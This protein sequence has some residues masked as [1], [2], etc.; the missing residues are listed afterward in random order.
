MTRPAPARA[1][2]TLVEV[3]GAFF[4]TVVVLFLVTGIFVEN[5]RQRAA[6][7]ALMR[8]RLAA[9]GALA[10][11]AEDLEGAVHVVRGEGVDPDAHP[12]RFE[13]DAPGDLGATA[14]RFVTQNAPRRNAG[15]HAGGWVEVEIPEPLQLDGTISAIA[16]TDAALVVDGGRRIWT[17]DRVCAG[18]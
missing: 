3:V 17:Y 2:F 9:T 6:A 14:I 10:L 4:L 11:L 16:A 5:G 8:E 13:A 18:I 15:E 12:W 1:G 7:T